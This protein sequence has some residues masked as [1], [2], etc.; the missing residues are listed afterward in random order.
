MSTRGTGIVFGVGIL[1]L[2][3]FL[4]FRSRRGETPLEVEPPPE[5]PPEGVLVPGIPRGDN[6]LT[7]ISGSVDDIWV[8]I[9]IGPAPGSQPFFPTGT[10]DLTIQWTGFPTNAQGS[11]ISWWWEVRARAIIDLPLGVTWF[12]KPYI[13]IA[14]NWAII[15]P[16]EDNLTR[17]PSAA[18]RQTTIRLRWPNPPLSIFPELY[19]LGVSVH[20]LGKLR[21]QAANADGTPATNGG[22]IIYDDANAVEF[23]KRDLFHMSASGG[24]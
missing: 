18:N 11:R 13:G 6:L 21:W 22:I 4:W 17:F 3:G 12:D 7:T 16:I 20:I 9:S 5:T 24:F 23:I 15:T 2:V 10:N 19:V 14:S 1:A 8:P